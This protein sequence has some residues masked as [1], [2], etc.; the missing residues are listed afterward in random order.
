MTIQGQQFLGTRGYRIGVLAVLAVVVLAAAAFFFGTGLRADTVASV[1]P[2][3]LG[4]SLTNVRESQSVAP[5]PLGS[6]LT[7]DRGS[8]AVETGRSAGSS[9]V[10]YASLGLPATAATKPESLADLEGRWAG[11][12][13]G[14]APSPLGS[15][16]TVDRGSTAAATARSAGLSASEYAAK[17]E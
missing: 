17:E 13:T 8:T 1:A 15:S 7:V 9:A 4:S 12:Y 3:P 5:S 2:S 14:V 16:L 11:F 10:D 6:S